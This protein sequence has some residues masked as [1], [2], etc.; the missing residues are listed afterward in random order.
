[1][2]LLGADAGKVAQVSRIIA[3]AQNTMAQVANCWLITIGQH[4][5][6]N[7]RIVSPIPGVESD[8]EWT[9]WFLTSRGSRKIADIRRDD[10]ITVGYQYDPDSAYVVLAGRGTISEDRSEI[11]RR[12]DQ[13]WNRVFPAGAEDPDALFVKGTIDRIELWNLAQKITPA[14]FGKRPAVL[15]RDVTRG[16]TSCA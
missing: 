6:P 11:A 9:I 5:E 4:G 16:W 1:M 14:P 10:R 7:A 8:E 13:S 3:A 12:W 15:I 2:T